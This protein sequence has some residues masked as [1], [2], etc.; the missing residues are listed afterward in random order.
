M[1]LRYT[2]VLCLFALAGCVA[3]PTPQPANHNTENFQFSAM[4]G[5]GLLLSG[6]LPD[7]AAQNSLMNLAESIFPDTTITNNMRSNGA[8]ASGWHRTTRWGL[9]S[10]SKLESGNLEIINHTLSLSGRA[11]SAEIKAQ[12]EAATIGLKAEIKATMQITVNPANQEAQITRFENHG[13][14]ND[15]NA[16]HH[17]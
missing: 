16:M 5:N 3:S 15:F 2:T 8:S 1:S 13:T 6:H 4:L 11:A 7:E 12:L 17:R 10:L 14:H 9:S